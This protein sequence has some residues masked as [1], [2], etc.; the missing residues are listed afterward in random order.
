M[1][2]KLTYLCC[3]LFSLFL[4]AS[5]SFAQTSKA[6]AGSDRRIDV[7]DIDS[8]VVIKTITGANAYRMVLTPDGKKL[9]ATD[10]NREVHI[11]DTE[12]DSLIKAFDP[13]QNGI[14][15]SELEGI[16]ISPDGKRVYVSDESSDN[17]FVIDTETD[18][19]V[20]AV[21][22]DLDEAEDMIVSP[23]GKWL[24]LNDNSDVVKISTDSLKIVATTNVSND[25]HG[26]TL[27][28]DGSK[29][30]AEGR[31]GAIRGV[32]VINADSM[33]IDTALTASGY[34]LECSIDGSRIFGVNESRRLSVI[35]ALA[36]TVLY[37]INFDQGGIRGI[38]E[39]VDQ[40]YILLASSS[41]LIKVDAQTD[42]ILV[43]NVG[44]GYRTVVVKAPVISSIG[45][46]EPNT[47]LQ[48]FKLKQN[49][50]NPFNPSTVISYELQTSGKV[51][52]VVFDMLGREVK[53][54][55]NKSQQAGKYN[56]VFDAGNLASGI[57]YYKLITG[58]KLEQTKK[59]LLVR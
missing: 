41:G 5:S 1:S 29:I 38:A 10:H 4:L 47:V 44:N 22:L 48:S 16:A 31:D 12:T 9:Y 45:A 42:S 55:V 26:I 23:D 28:K 8:M 59:M 27:N 46:P 33:V 58:K 34:H 50:P 56:V 25:G 19:V 11:I 20:A 2:I 36:D 17:L 57:Y 13:S 30:Y 39:T 3:V 32:V 54:L 40:K 18:S 7:I 49:Y 51:N 24:Y 15:T 14:N 21:A 53:T 37:E 6:Y 35:D 43:T 52:L